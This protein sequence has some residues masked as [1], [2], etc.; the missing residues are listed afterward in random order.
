MAEQGIP[1]A[2]AI[3]VYRSTLAR[4]DRQ[5]GESGRFG[6]DPVT[7]LHI[8]PH[9]FDARPLALISKHTVQLSLRVRTGFLVERVCPYV[10]GL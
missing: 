2:L 9:I 5:F 10:Y 6:H 8:A 3:I 7:S 1:L 4:A